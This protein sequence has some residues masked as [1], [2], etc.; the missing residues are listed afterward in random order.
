MSHKN[1]EAYKCLNRTSHTLRSEHWSQHMFSERF[2]CNECMSA[3]LLLTLLLLLILS[4][5][6]TFSTHIVPENT[7]AH[8]SI[9]RL[10]LFSSL[11]RGVSVERASFSPASSSQCKRVECEQQ[12]STSGPP[13]RYVCNVSFR[14]II[15]D[16]KF[17]FVI[18]YRNNNLFT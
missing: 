14:K 9:G 2:S 8:R 18:N 4:Q 15:S 16:D 13:K 1:L 10:K 17:F 12:A 3:L 6:N 7:L 11:L 5:N